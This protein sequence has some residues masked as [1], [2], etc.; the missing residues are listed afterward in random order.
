MRRDFRP[1]LC[2]PPLGGLCCARCRPLRERARPHTPSA[3]CERVNA[4]TPAAEGRRVELRR[5][6]IR[7][8]DG[9][10]PLHAGGGHPAGGPAAAAQPHTGGC[11]CTR[12]SVHSHVRVDFRS[13][14]A[15]APPSQQAWHGM[16]RWAV[17]SVPVVLVLH[18]CTQARAAVKDGAA[19]AKH[20]PLAPQDPAR[21]LS[22]HC[23]AHPTPPQP[24]VQRILGV[25]YTF[26]ADRQLSL[27]CKD[28]IQRMLARGEQAAERGGRESEG[29]GRERVERERGRGAPPSPVSLGPGSSPGCR[30][31]AQAARAC[32]RRAT[33]PGSRCISL[34]KACLCAPARI[35]TSAAAG[36]SS[37]ASGGTFLCAA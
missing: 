7:A 22:L 27:S 10:L 34:H 12:I 15:A 29:G 21:P 23:V 1:L 32:T 35:A 13:Q 19:L 3:T 9:D 16:L 8:G 33:R 11:G 4:H 25:A 28:L 20:R 24:P 36:P 5:A 2:R 14:G 18:M 26:P 31:R 17:A 6:L 37:G 30:Q